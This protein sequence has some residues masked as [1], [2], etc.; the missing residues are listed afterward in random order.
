MTSAAEIR[1][2]LDHPVIDADGHVVE[3]LPVVVDYIR[4]VAGDDAADRLLPSSVTYSIS[5]A[6]TEGSVMAPWWTIP[7]NARDRA[8][9]FLPALLHERMDEIGID[10]GILYSSVGLLAFSH[11]DD[12]TRRAPAGGSTPTWP[13]SSRGSATGCARRP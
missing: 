2:R 5:D 7:T 6:P 12:V 4:R 1:G 13:T 8:T 11:E 9:S 3:A 10:F